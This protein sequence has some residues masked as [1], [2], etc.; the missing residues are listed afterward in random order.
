[1]DEPRI[2]ETR[3]E[4]Q[5][6]IWKA[7]TD[8]MTND[9]ITELEKTGHKVCK[10]CN[11]DKPLKEYPIDR[12]HKDGHKSWCIN[13]NIIKT[14]E[15]EDGRKSYH[16]QYRLTHKE[17]SSKYHKNQ[18]QQL[19]VLV[20][21]YYGNGKCKCVR[22]GFSDIWALTIDHINGNG[23][24]HRKENHTHTGL[25]FYKWLINNNYPSGFRT[26][27][28]NCQSIVEYEKRNAK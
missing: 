9:K 11:V 16:A 15:Y 10:L 25:H 20:I 2:G 4:H 19:K 7:R 28:G 14:K 27:C 8:R 26:L 24:K 13:C 17:E 6:R 1:M 5:H 23:N 22:C 18:L 3:R 21:E 12:S